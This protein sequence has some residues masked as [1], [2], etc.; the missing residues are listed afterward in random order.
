V[1]GK[2][3]PFAVP[4]GF[5]TTVLKAVKRTWPI[6]QNRLVSLEPQ[7]PHIL[8]TGGDHNVQVHA[9]DLTTSTIRPVWGRA[10]AGAGDAC[11][12]RESADRYLGF[13]APEGWQSGR[14]HRS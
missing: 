7:T 5:W 13:A 1:I 11:A 8:A 3:E 4:S 2:T 10:R 6:M 12:A 9:P 14:M